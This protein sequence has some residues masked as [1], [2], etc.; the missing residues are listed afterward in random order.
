MAERKEI[1]SDLS[2]KIAD[3][4]IREAYRT[5]EELPVADQIAVSISPGVGDALAAYE[6]KEFGSRAKTNIQDKDYLGAA[7]NIALSALSGISLIPLFR[8][9]R[10]ARGVTKSATQA[11]DASKKLKP[12]VEEPLPLAPPKE[13]KLPKVEPF[14]PKGIKDISYQAGDFQ[15]GSKAR[16]WVNGIEQPNITTLGKKVQKLP[17][18]QWVQK[19]E[20]AGIPKGELRLLNILDESN[21]I[22]PKLIMSADA[23][24][25]LSRQSLD[26]YIARSQRNAI[27]IRN[28][29]QDL[30]ESVTYRPDTIDPATQGQFNYFVR[31]SGEFRNK[32]HH[33]VKLKYPDGFS[34][35]NSYVFDG[36]GKG[37][38]G[39][40][41]ERLK[42]TLSPKDFKTISKGL[43]ELDINPTRQY[44]PVGKNLFRIQSD[45][46]EEVSKI[47]RK[48]QVRQFEAAK[49]NFD[50][51]SRIPRVYQEANK[52]IKDA[53]SVGPDAVIT[54]TQRSELISNFK[55]EFDA[56][57]RA[58]DEQAMR[59]ILGNDLYKTFTD[60]GFGERVPGKYFAPDQDGLS[61]VKRIEIEISSTPNFI[62]T[63]KNIIKLNSK[64]EDMA[65][66][67]PNLENVVKEVLE[68]TKNVEK[69][70]Q[71]I[72][73]SKPTGF[74]KP[75][76]QKKLIKGLKSYNKKV[77]EINK[78]IADGADID[79][80]KI[81]E[82]LGEDILRLGIDEFSI[83]PKDIER[84][85]GKPFTESLP[86]S[87]DEIYYE[88]NPATGRQ[89][90]FDA[91]NNPIDRAAAYF[92]EIA[93]QKTTFLDL[94]DGVKVLKK[95]VSVNQARLGIK[96]DP[97]FDGGN[98]KY[99]KLPVRTNI[100]DSANKGDEY[101][102][103]G[104]QQAA[105]EGFNPELVKTYESAQKEIKKVLKELGVGEEGVV[106]TIKGTGTAFDGT[107]LKFTDELKRAIETQG[108][109]AFKDGG[110]VDIDK[111]LAEL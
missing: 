83:T 106:K 90:Y 27:Q 5:F 39:Y 67:D 74:V 101:L 97:Y 29:P 103:I 99:F 80:N 77:D 57:L 51:I 93:D 37:N 11:A 15:F 95:A 40:E 79:L 53:I 24:K 41:L 107:Y 84:I 8:F 104:N 9:L 45:F 34:G 35:D 100:L 23:K 71:K 6:I 7:G 1:L 98:S 108:I 42:I 111:M 18:E 72:F 85:T 78:A 60:T 56:A 88:I 54:G 50:S 69:I 4:N 25:S 44:I 73:K 28:T 102:F 16:K 82:S 92:D 36:T 58:N 10:G 70:K 55:P 52:S 94:S 38:V 31:G 43:K 65:K 61:V 19:L 46:Q 110:A 32:P 3:G 22:H 26:D 68:R 76:I 59:K 96:I 21:S 91:G 89:K 33:N 14:E 66:L 20:N 86:K 47:Y 30:L 12:P 109:N 17:A 48:T 81:N 75:E 63:P 105:Q 13:T 87:I 49:T 62:L 64:L 2:S